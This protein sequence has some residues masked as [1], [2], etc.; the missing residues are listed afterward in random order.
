MTDPTAPDPKTGEPK[1]GE[2]KTGDSGSGAYQVLARKYRP[3]RF[4]D[5]I[6]QEAAVRTLT[7]RWKAGAW[8]RPS[9]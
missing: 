7:T 2:S 3:A 1:T 4:A 5:L 9:S 6:G 8:P